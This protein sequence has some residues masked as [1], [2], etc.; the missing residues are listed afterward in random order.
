M[1]GSLDVGTEI[2]APPWRDVVLVL[3]GWWLV[4]LLAGVLAAPQDR[5]AF[6][7]R[8]ALVHL[9]GAIAFL[10]FY[11]AMGRMVV[12]FV[13]FATLAAVSVAGC[14]SRVRWQT[15]RPC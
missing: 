13:P 6:R 12:Y 4:I 5:G 2:L 7:S 14:S 8:E 10:G 11:L 15:S 3:G 9:G 1:M